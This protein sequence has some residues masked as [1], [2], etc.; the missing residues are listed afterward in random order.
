MKQLLLVSAMAALLFSCSGGQSCEKSEQENRLQL[1]LCLKP[2]WKTDHSSFNDN[3][4][5]RSGKVSVELFGHAMGVDEPIEPVQQTW[6]KWFALGGCVPTKEEGIKINDTDAWMGYGFYE[7]QKTNKKMCQTMAYVQKNNREYFIQC[8]C[9]IADQEA[10]WKM[11][12]E[13][14]QSITFLNQ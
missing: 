9:E 7:D 1:E 5:V 6:G 12:K 11:V 14:S 10:S 13:V 2:G 4:T 8:R 3:Y